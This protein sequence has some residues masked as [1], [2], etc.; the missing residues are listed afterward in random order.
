MV[1]LEGSRSCLVTPDEWHHVLFSIDMGGK[2]QANGTLFSTIV[3]QG[4]DPPYERVVDTP[5]AI[6]SICKVW[7]AID[8][9]NVFGQSLTGAFP[10]MGLDKNDLVSRQ[11]LNAWHAGN[12]NNYTTHSFAQSI[13]EGHSGFGF[14]EEAYKGN[15]ILPSYSLS[16][17]RLETDGKPIGIPSTKEWGIDE[18]PGSILRSEM[19]EFQMWTDVTLDTA[20]EINRRAFIDYERDGNGHPV[21]DNDGN[22]TLMP[23]KPEGQPATDDRPVQP[24]PAEKLLGK[25]PEILLHGSNNWIDGKNTGTTGF[26]YSTDPPTVKP[27]GQ[28]NRTGGIKKYTPDPSLKQNPPPPGSSRKARPALTKKPADARL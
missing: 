19:A 24:A 5:P 23:V 11:T 22:F 26:D 6:S 8:D 1:G 14:W 16:G 17:A 18:L 4:A 15:D 9:E 25:K 28:F 12:T 10:E 21:R 27:I 13:T 7:L 20:V 3:T 2:M